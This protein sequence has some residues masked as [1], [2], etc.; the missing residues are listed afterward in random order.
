MLIITSE[1]ELS[2]NGELVYTII[3]RQ[4]ERQHLA[5]PSALGNRPGPGN[6]HGPSAL[7]NRLGP[8]NDHGPSALGNRFGLGNDHVG[9]D[10]PARFW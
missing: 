8:G 5:K 7:G 2:S 1:D 4:P 10:D 9:R 6:D 3:W